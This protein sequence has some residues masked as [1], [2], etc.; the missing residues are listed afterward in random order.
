MFNLVSLFSEIASEFFIGDLVH[1]RGVSIPVGKTSARGLRIAQVEIDGH[2][3]K[4]IEQNPNKG[5]VHAAQAKA[6]H[7]VIQ[8]LDGCGRYLGKSVDGKVELYPNTPQVLGNKEVVHDR[9]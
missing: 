9:P 6:G 8:F 5:S 7:K 2:T 4:A 3:I 1:A